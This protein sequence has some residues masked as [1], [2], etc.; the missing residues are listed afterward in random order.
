[1]RVTCM[2]FV[3]LAF[4]ACGDDESGA[5][6]LGADAA[7]QSADVGRP[8]A[9][10]DA[11]APVRDA[12]APPP[13]TVAPPLDADAPPPDADAPPPPTAPPT[14]APRPPPPDTA[15]LTSPPGF[16]FARGLIHMHS[17]HSHD[18]CDGDP[19]PGGAPN[20]PC[21]ADL[22]AAVCRSRLDYML[23]T[24]HP[25]SFTEVTFEEAVLHDASAGDTLLRDDAG[26]V[27][28]GALACADGHR[29][30]IA[31]GAESDLMPV[32]LRRP[33]ETND[34]YGNRSAASVEGLRGAG[35]VVL[36]AHTEERTFEELWP[37]G[38]DGFEIYNLH[39]N[40]N[41]RWRQL[42]EV[43]PDIIQV[44]QAGPDGPHPDLSLLAALRENP[45]ALD[46]WNRFIARRRTLGVA[47]SDI[48][49]N[50]PA[51]LFRPTDGERLDSYRRMTTWFANY[52]LVPAVTL[53]TLR[54][55][56][57][58]GRAYVVFHLLGE[59]D[60][61]DFALT[62]ATGARH[63]VGSEV[64][65]MPGLNLRLTPPSV[66]GDSPIDVRLVRVRVAD[67]ADGD[68]PDTVVE[69]VADGTGALDFAIDAPGAYR[70]E[71]RQTP[72]HLRAELGNL[73]DLLVRPT[74]WIY[75]NPI[76][77]R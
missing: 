54:D 23:L 77:V 24:D 48:H 66:P 22:R 37:L 74:I 56:L 30:L 72:E 40:V 12:D 75:S 47:G 64:A 25:D 28:G 73:A 5:R 62:D 15:T 31:P 53:D 60:G 14:R 67:E 69:L 9:A 1:M 18:A 70:V 3:G 57:L 44:L 45:W 71:I 11:R 26:G 39:A 41:P 59:P 76:Y 50:L 19:K 13:D 29:V 16:V 7:A 17:V 21:L 6:R 27:I 38:L 34:W 8:P 49:Q 10:T 68:G 36:H 4:V 46:T 63:E 35:A 2:S 51:A 43:L 61:L 32:M 58:E 52:L 33:P 20:A 55:A 65:F 42:A